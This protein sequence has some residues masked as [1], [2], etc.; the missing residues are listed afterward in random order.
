M[1]THF[2]Y[3]LVA[4]L[5]LLLTFVASVFFLTYGWNGLISDYYG[6]RQAQTAISTFYLVHESMQL[7]YITPVLGY[8]WAIPFEFPSYQFV[9]ALVVKMFSLQVDQAGRL[10]SLTCFYLCI[11]P[12]Y[13]IFRQAKLERGDI[14]IIIILFLSS[15]FYLFWSRTFMIESMALL[16]SLM[17]INMVVLY[18]NKESL[19][20]L[21]LGFIFALL[22]ALTKVTTFVVAGF[23]ATS[24]IVYL[25]GERVDK[26]S[27]N[28]L[29]NFIL[30]GIITMGI[31][32][33]VSIVWNIYADSLKALNPLAQFILS[34]N[35]RDWNFGTI[36]Q[37]FSLEVLDHL[38]WRF[39]NIIGYSWNFSTLD[40]R[41]FGGD[42]GLLRKVL[43]IAHLFCAVAAIGAVIVTSRYRIIAIGLTATFLVAPLLLI[44]LYFEHEYY[45]YACGIYLLCV[46]ALGI[47][48]IIDWQPIIGFLLLAILLIARADAYL[49]Q[50]I[51]FIDHSQA[52]NNISLYEAIKENVSKDEYIVGI[53][54]T[55]SSVIPY[56]SERKAIM[57]NTEQIAQASFAK[58]VDSIGK[59]NVAAIVA[60]GNLA[61]IDKGK[62]AE[63]LGEFSNTPFYEGR[64]CS[65]FLR[66]DV[67]RNIM[68]DLMIES[69]ASSEHLNMMSKT[70]LFSHAPSTTK[71]CVSNMSSVSLGYGIKRAAMNKTA[72]ACFNVSLI[73][74]DSVSE[75][76]VSECISGGVIPSDDYGEFYKAFDEPSTG[77]LV[78]NNNCIAPD[79]GWAWT[80]WDD[81]QIKQVE[82]NEH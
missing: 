82:D 28:V 50:Y 64:Q 67:N 38:L 26:F 32:L 55:W 11:F 66:I 8:P 75:V 71:V 35:L 12:I 9:V 72:G 70:K 29:R 80:Y 54:D 13:S 3:Q 42:W 65:L 10:I 21:L 77:C 43:F 49:A 56:Y 62:L 53:G 59:R 23:F 81:L 6:F 30:L 16:W 1:Q 45:F 14:F 15:P 34:K 68:R 27:F 19:R 61:L 39:S 20:Y 33:G 7:N 5:M 57:I 51:P 63:V 41:I 52:Y 22:A 18:I 79:C 40:L 25:W 46:I 17:F 48:M 76:L 31:P 78:L 73:R 60:C 58:S 4:L 37:R 36:E 2:K 74:D 47:I 44:N 24:L 69:D